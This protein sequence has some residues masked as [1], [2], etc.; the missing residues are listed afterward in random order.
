MRKL[1]SCLIILSL[2]CLLSS[3]EDVCPAN[4]QKCKVEFH[5]LKKLLAAITNSPFAPTIPMLRK[6]EEFHKAANECSVCNETFLDFETVTIK[7]ISRP[8]QFEKECLLPTLKALALSQKHCARSFDFFE[9][10][11]SN[12]SVFHNQEAK[13]CFLAAMKDITNEGCPKRLYNVFD[14]NYT[15]IMEGY[16]IYSYFPYTLKFQKIQCVAESGFQ[17]LYDRINVE[18]STTLEITKE[19]GKWRRCDINLL[20]PFRF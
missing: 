17:S 5:Q 7:V 20:V 16:T 2:S 8:Y 6:L 11:S 1:T 9:E 13:D 19:F 14:E 18:N 10:V 3:S 15:Q 4:L 12:T